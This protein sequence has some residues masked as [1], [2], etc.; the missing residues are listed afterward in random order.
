MFR[1][2]CPVLGKLLVNVDIV[3][4]LVYRPGELTTMAMSFLRLRDIWALKRMSPVDLHHLKSFL[5]KNINVMTM[6][7]WVWRGLVI[8]DLMDNGGGYEFEKGGVRTAVQVSDSV[9]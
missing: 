8:S 6:A 7:S 5:K 1:S 3:K 2:V 4:Y 9:P